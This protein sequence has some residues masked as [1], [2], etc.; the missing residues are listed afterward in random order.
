MGYPGPKLLFRFSTAHSN[1]VFRIAY[2]LL[3]LLRAGWAGAD[4]WE[5]DPTW[6]HMLLAVEVV[7][8][9]H[10]IVHLHP[11]RYPYTLGVA[12]VLDA[13]T[14]LEIRLC[15]SCRPNFCRW[16]F[17]L[18]VKIIQAVI[19][20]HHNLCRNP[21]SCRCTV[22]LD[23]FTHSK[24]RGLRILLRALGDLLL[25]YD[26]QEAPETRYCPQP[27]RGYASIRT[28]H[29]QQAHELLRLS[30]VRT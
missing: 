15:K 29:A 13:C 2:F 1:A 5:P 18:A 26:S 20:N 19:A 12:Q 16:H 3:L 8:T 6:R 30:A 10:G 21:R 11:C 4:G 27:S 7:G 9:G 22:V 14:N 24:S 25:L 23:E 17:L 28:R